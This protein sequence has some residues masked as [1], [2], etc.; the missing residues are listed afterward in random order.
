MISRHAAGLVAWC[1]VAL[2]A[3]APNRS[4]VYVSALAEGDRAHAAGRERE[5]AGAYDEA[6]HATTRPLDRDEATYRAAMAWRHVG[7]TAASLERFDWLT[8]HAQ[9]WERGERAAFEAGRMR[10]ESTDATVSAR[11][12]T[13]LEALVVRSPDTGP[14]RRAVDLLLER[15][16]GSDPSGAAALAWIEET[17]PR[18]HGHDLE[19][20][21]RWLRA[22][23]LEALGRDDAA[24]AAYEQL[25]EIPYPRN[26]HW[27][28]GGLAF[29]LHLRSLGRPADALSVIE[30]ILSRREVAA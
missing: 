14:A 3:C 1:A 24:L 19:I 4:T 12:A 20:A 26:M 11:G 13:D 16:D 2:A 10:L 9:R 25:L 28:D 23:R 15:L 8:T 7:D 17:E 21:L 29:A 6:A 27:D 5:A 30:R 22:R 18:V